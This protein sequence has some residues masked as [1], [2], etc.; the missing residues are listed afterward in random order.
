[1]IY[2]GVA[3]FFFV[4]LKRIIRGFVQQLICRAYNGYVTLFRHDFA[5]YFVYILLKLFSG[6][7]AP[8]LAFGKSPPWVSV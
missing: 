3:G 1:M 6:K 5:C 8:F 2:K 4:R 7:L